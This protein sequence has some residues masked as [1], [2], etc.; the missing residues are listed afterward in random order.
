MPTR[1]QIAARL[2][3]VDYTAIEVDEARGTAFLG[4]AG[5]RVHLGGIGKGF[6]VDRAVAIPARP[7]LARLPRAG[8]RRLLRVRH[9]R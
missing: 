7:R 2:P 6:A 5:M 8:R 9:A 3:L 1:E 4:R